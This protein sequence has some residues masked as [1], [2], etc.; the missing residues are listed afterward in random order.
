MDAPFSPAASSPAD[1][2]ELF[3]DMMSQPSRACC[4]FVHLTRLPLT[5]RQVVLGR[6][7]Q[8]LDS[9]PNP[10]KQVPCLVERDGFVLP[11]SSAILKYL[12][13]RH[14]VADHWYP[15]ELR[16]R[17]R[18]NAAL[19]WQHFSL[20]RGAAGVTW[21]SLIARNMGMKTDPGMARAMLNVLRGALGKLEKTWLTDEAPFMMGSSQPCIADLLVSEVSFLLTTST[22][23]G[24]YSNPALS[25]RRKS[26]T[27]RSS[28]RSTRTLGCLPRW[29]RCSGRITRGSPGS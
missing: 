13:D 19:D 14:A 16:A 5:R 23:P 8:L 15:R 27:S 1:G 12:A 11:E 29:M 2:G 4:F 22:R 28:R 10:L 18:V 24:S 9:F 17:A 7:E 3:V 6:K 21:F 20:R 25:T 26:S